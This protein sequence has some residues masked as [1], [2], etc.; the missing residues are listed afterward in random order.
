MKVR[1]DVDSIHSGG[2]GVG[3]IQGALIA[4]FYPKKITNFKVE[5]IQDLEYELIE[6]GKFILQTNE[7]TVEFKPIIIQITKTGRMVNNK[8]PEYVGIL[9]SKQIRS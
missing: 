3:T 1:Y 6:E 5:I 7:T 9:Q 4:I 8:L 2:G